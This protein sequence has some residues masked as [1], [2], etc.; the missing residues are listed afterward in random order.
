MRNGYTGWKISLCAAV[1]C[2]LL[3]FFPATASGSLSFRP[4]LG[5]I[6]GQVNRC[7]AGDS[8]PPFIRWQHSRCMCGRVGLYLWRVRRE[9]ALPNKANWKSIFLARPTVP[10]NFT[11]QAAHAKSG[12]CGLGQKINGLF[13]QDRCYAGRSCGSCTE[14]LIRLKFYSRKTED[15]Q[16]RLKQGRHLLLSSKLQRRAVN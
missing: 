3:L 15:V 10:S 4:A 13:I 6:F 5:L 14:C 12:V 9:K 16:R 2:W 11:M 8:M 7:R 1:K